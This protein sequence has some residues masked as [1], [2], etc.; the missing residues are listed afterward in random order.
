MGIYFRSK[1]R[2]FALWL[3]SWTDPDRRTL[4]DP[5]DEA[6]RQAFL[7]C[8]LNVQFLAPDFDVAATGK[9]HDVLHHAS[10][11]LRIQHPVRTVADIKR[12]LS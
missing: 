7:A 6:I 11:H 3:L 10:N 4:P 1:L 8:G 2:R 12:V 5:V 9:L